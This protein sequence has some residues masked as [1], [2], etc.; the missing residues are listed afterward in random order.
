MRTR[1][2]LTDHSAERFVVY[3][4]KGAIFESDSEDEAREEFSSL[5][6]FTGDLVLARIMERRR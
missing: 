6:K 4:D 5:E 3:D 2:S 1:Y